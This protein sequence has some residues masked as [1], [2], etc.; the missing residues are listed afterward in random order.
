MC[1]YERALTVKSVPVKQEALLAKAANFKPSST[2]TKEQ[3]VKS[4]KH[5]NSIVCHYCKQAGHIVRKCEKWI[6]DG[7]PPKPANPQVTNTGQSS[8]AHLVSLVAVHND[9][10]SVDKSMFVDEWFAISLSGVTYLRVSRSS[11]T[12]TRYKLR[13]E[14]LPKLLEDVMFF[15]KPQ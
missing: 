8:S 1:S 7:G 11:Q 2:V 3:K 14:M 9:V 4:T 13:M 6:V 5:G 15:W 10:F 12:R